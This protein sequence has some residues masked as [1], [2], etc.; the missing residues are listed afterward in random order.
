MKKNIKSQNIFRPVRTCI[1]CMAKK[2]K[3]ELLRF[4]LRE[5][6][7]VFLDR[8]QNSPGRGAYLCPDKNCL[9]IA[10]KKNQFAR[11]FRQKILTSSYEQLKTEFTTCLKTRSAH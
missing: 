2:N 7:A 6:G 9:D 4:I 1:G 11:A 10:I 5:D 8:E 3:S